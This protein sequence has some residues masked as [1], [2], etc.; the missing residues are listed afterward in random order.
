ML[1]SLKSILVLV[2]SLHSL[3]MYISMITVCPL[4]SIFWNLAI[5]FVRAHA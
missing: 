4:Y 1:G 2:S 3:F 5:L